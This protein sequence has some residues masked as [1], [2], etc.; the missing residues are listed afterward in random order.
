MTG[1]IVSMI[2]MIA[3]IVCMTSACL[4]HNQK[5]LDICAN[6]CAPYGVKACF[7]DRV[8]CDKESVELKF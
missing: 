1:P 6:K 8:I 3:A 7:K 5:H 4:S 2:I